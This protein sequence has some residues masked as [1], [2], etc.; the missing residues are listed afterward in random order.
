MK[1]MVRMMLHNS[2]CSLLLLPLLILTTLAQQPARSTP[3]LTT[4]DVLKRNPAAVGVRRA[5][6]TS[7]QRNEFDAAEI[8]WNK[9]YNE[10][11]LKLKDLERRADQADLTAQQ[12]RNAIYPGPNSPDRLN[13]LHAQFNAQKDLSRR[14]R[15]EAAVVRT[16]L[17]ALLDEARSSGFAVRDYALFRANGEPDYDSFR[18]R[19]ARLSRDLRDAESR[20]AVRQLEVNR[21]FTAYRA[22]GCIPDSQGICRNANDIFY[23][24]R[25]RAD[26]RDARNNLDA[27]QARVNALKNDLASLM[28]TGRRNDVPPGIFRE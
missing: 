27:A 4:D 19:Y 3:A 15:A 8:D 23:Q 6:Q 13:A 11:L 25:L 21:I 14:L 24:N 20:V 16:A 7:S 2:V 26:L 17:N 1:T 10:T 5:V 18:E 12:A 9:R 22:I 28:E